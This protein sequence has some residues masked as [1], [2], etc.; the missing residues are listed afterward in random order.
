[1]HYIPQHPTVS[2][3]MQSFSS[4]LIEILQ[5]FSL[6]QEVSMD[7]EWE[8]NFTRDLPLLTTF[9]CSI[10]HLAQMLEFPVCK[11]FRTGSEQLS[12]WTSQRAVKAQCTPSGTWNT[13]WVCFLLR[14]VSKVNP[15]AE[16]VI[17]SFSSKAPVRPGEDGSRVNWALADPIK[18]SYSIIDFFN[19][20]VVKSLK[21]R[22]LKILKYQ[23]PWVY[24]ALCLAN[25]GI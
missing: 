2:S 1:M 4:H 22:S 24:N 14:G 8:P 23:F 15:R 3:C 12:S 7:A 19:I 21:S 20:N 18:I 25:L 17:F 6:R 16:L 10:T 5:Q 13:Y 9:L 11:L